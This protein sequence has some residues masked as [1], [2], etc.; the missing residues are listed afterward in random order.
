MIITKCKGE[1]HGQCLGCLMKGKWN[2]NWL[3]F[4][5]KIP[6]LDGTYCFDCVKEI[7]KDEIEIQ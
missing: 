7:V 4:L 2:M 1:G 3:C 6:G 5:Y